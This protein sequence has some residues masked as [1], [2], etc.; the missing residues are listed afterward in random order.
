MS[1]NALKH[2]HILT[3]L[4]FKRV[5]LGS[6]LGLGLGLGF[7]LGFKEE[8]GG[9]LL[10]FQ[11]SH[12]VQRSWLFVFFTLVLELCPRP[13][14]KKKQT[15]LLKK[16][17]KKKCLGKSE[18]IILKVKEPKCEASLW[19]WWS[20]R[21]LER[22][23]RNCFPDPPVSAD[24]GWSAPLSPAAEKQTHFFFHSTTFC[25]KTVKRKLDMYSLCK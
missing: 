16:I 7:G 3:V 6:G 1:H 20:S 23:W 10:L 13:S 17:G 18:K 25:Y 19:N 21:Y 5:F 12:G 15:T 11:W 9:S 22:L 14:F 2:N 24:P 8:E 4:K